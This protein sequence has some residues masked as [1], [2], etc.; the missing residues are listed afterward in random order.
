MKEA[1]RNLTGKLLPGSI[2]NEKLAER[3]SYFY[4]TGREFRAIISEPCDP[5]AEVTG[6]ITN[7][8]DILIPIN[9]GAIGTNKGQVPKENIHYCI[10]HELVELG[11][12]D[13]PEK[14][15]QAAQNV[16][17]RTVIPGIEHTLRFHDLPHL[18][19]IGAEYAATL[20]RGQTRKEK[21]VELARF[22][23]TDAMAKTERLGENGI[24]VDKPSRAAMLR[25]ILKMGLAE[26]DNLL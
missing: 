7:S 1:I 18:T 11:V 10:L 16:Y 24:D 19:A 8:G 21:K 26:L 14:V 22:H 5:G 3:T 6:L 2:I 9:S 13:P 4:I 23:R 12:V 17:D 20:T 15:K 25:E